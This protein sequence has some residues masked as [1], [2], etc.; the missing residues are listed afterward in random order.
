MVPLPRL[1]INIGERKKKRRG[2]TGGF[3]NR[4][5]GNI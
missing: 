3:E 2:G 4:K 5:E 1:P